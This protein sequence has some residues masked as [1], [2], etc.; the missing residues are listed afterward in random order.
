MLS[1]RNITRRRDR[2]AQLIGLL[3]FSTIVSAV[4]PARKLLTWPDSRNYWRALVNVNQYIDS[5]PSDW[6]IRDRLITDLSIIQVKPSDTQN[7]EA[8]F[9]SLYA[10]WHARGLIVGTYISGRSVIPA[11]DM[12]Q[13]PPSEVTI[14]QMPSSAKYVT[15][16]TGE[17]RRKILDLS[18]PLTRK[19]FQARVKEIW[20]SD[21]A[22]LRFVDNAAVHSSAGKEQAWSSYCDNMRELRGI[23]H[24]QGARVIF[25]IA[26]HIGKL[27]TEEMQQLIDAVGTDGISL[28]MPF[29]EAI[30]A[31]PKETEA[32][33]LAYRRVLD[34]GMAV[35]LIPADGR[36][37]E[38]AQWVTTWRKPADHLYI[39]EPFWKPPNM[40]VVAKGDNAPQVHHAAHGN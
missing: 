4:I 35:V 17:P 37:Q 32:A 18:D 30:A 28:E 25:N 20:A 19:A 26:A 11:A 36:E 5:R 14:E 23:A 1:A 39:S 8:Q 33:R 34:S 6:F 12:V 9:R 27:S 40:L 7:A 29:H 10:K 13:Y 31:D 15:T 38:L 3:A 2:I 21:P 24:T 22:Q 16:W